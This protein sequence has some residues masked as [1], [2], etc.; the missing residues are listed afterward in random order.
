LYDVLMVR[1]ARNGVAYGEN[2]IAPMIFKFSEFPFDDA[3]YPRLTMS[4]DALTPETIRTYSGMQRAILQRQ[5]WAIFDATAPSRFITIRPHD[6]RRIAVRRQL[7]GLIRE[8]ALKRSEIESLPDSFRTTA[9]AKKYPTEFD[10]DKPTSPFLPPDLTEDASAWICFGRS[11]TPVNLHAIEGR[12]RSAFFQFIQLPGGR[13]A[14]IEY[15]DRWKEQNAFPVGTQVALIEKAFLVSDKGEL[16][17][18]PITLSIQVRAYRN[19]EQSVSDADTATQCVAEFISRP[20]DYLRGIAL[21]AAISPTDYRLKTLRSDGGKQDVLELVNDPKTS[22]QTRLQQC[23]QC[24][25]GVGVNSLGDVVAPRGTLMSFQRR[26]KKEIVQATAKAKLE[27]ESWR[28]L[29]AEWGN[30]NR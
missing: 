17:L 11:S 20:R 19:V 25:G 27:D 28:L 15:I 21:M 23:M 24:H 30:A 18:S 16:V 8:L 5:L 2:E 10:L 9:N 4:L 12:W 13:D 22:L 3:T 14:T 26:S 29:L 6:A 7:A 1:H